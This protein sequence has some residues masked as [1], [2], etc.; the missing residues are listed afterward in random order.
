MTALAT[1]VPMLAIRALLN[2]FLRPARKRAA[3]R[4]LWA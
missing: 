2:S 4:R 3:R 1:E